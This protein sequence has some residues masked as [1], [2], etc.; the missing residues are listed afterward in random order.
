M[1]L[2]TEPNVVSR[3]FVAKLPILVSVLTAVRILRL[4]R[5]DIRINLAF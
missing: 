1:L 3:I 5:Y 2:M 4:D